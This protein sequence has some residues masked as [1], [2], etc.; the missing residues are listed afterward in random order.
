[1]KEKLKLLITKPWAAYTVATCSAVLIYLFFS[2]LPAVKAVL[3]KLYTYISPV[4]IGIVVAYVFNPVENFF[5]F[6]VL[7]K[8]K[9][10]SSRHTAAVILTIV[11]IVILLGMF[12]CVLIPSLIKSISKLIENWD[13]YILKAQ[14]LI[15]KAE[16]F[17]AAHNINFDFEGVKNY[18]DNASDTLTKYV[19]DNYQSIL[20]AAGSVGSS[21]S[22][23]AIG[24]LFGFCF[25]FS[26]QF[27][28]G[29]V[30]RVRSAFLSSH[31]IERHN[32]L[33]SRCNKIFV[34]YLGCTLLDSLIVGVC[35]LIFTLATGMSYAPLIAFICG[36]TNIIPTVGPWIGTG[37]GIFFLL[38]DKP[39]N[40][41]WF[42][43]FCCVLQGIDGMVIKPKLFKNGLGI[44]AAWSFIL[45]IIGGKIA[46]I[47]G[48]IL[49]IP[50]GAVLEILYEETLIPWLDKKKQTKNN[51]AECDDEQ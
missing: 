3:A 31:T 13:G 22:N 46:G 43:I 35:T 17:A 37:I 19:K 15:G 38:L 25:L 45:L 6:K 11:M 24:V 21:V 9:K 42:V 51:T 23:F 50:A 10:E 41:L 20:S 7:K 49:S 28:L 33:F 39:V 2:N 4:V 40:V 32:E 36:F 29:F 30:N 18:M 48:I 34:R 16:V 14:E 27:L 12:L 26:E 47:T 5:E 44:P 1:M 8:T